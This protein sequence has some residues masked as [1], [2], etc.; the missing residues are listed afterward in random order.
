M[1]KAYELSDTDTLSMNEVLA[2]LRCVYTVSEESSA[3]LSYS[4]CRLS[5][6][7]RMKQIENLNNISLNN[8][9]QR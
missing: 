1:S 6:G 8:F 2:D 4:H 5:R 7:Q 3:D 9:T